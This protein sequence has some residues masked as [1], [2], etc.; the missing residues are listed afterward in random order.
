MRRTLKTPLLKGELIMGMKYPVLKLLMFLLTQDV[1]AG[2]PIAA[3]ELEFAA[4]IR[5]Y[6]ANA[7]GKIDVDERKGYVRERARLLREE[8]RRAAA[9]R[10]V[11]PPELRPFV[12]L[13]NWTKEKV[14]RY[15]NNR[16]G[17]LD[18]EERRQERLD[19]IQAARTQFKKADSNGDGRVDSR[20]QQAALTRGR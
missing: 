15:D 6:D 19:A 3:T 10:P 1:L 4:V 14:T 5:K 11:T 12:A 8:A 20:E 17:K 16:N 13:P 7:N 9:Q 18:P 2:D